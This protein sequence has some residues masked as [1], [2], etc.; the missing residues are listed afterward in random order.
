MNRSILTAWVYPLTVGLLIVGL[1]WWL[2]IGITGAQER[3]TTERLVQTLHTLE[4]ELVLLYEATTVSRTAHQSLLFTECSGSQRAAYDDA[5][6]ALDE[7]LTVSDGH[8]LLR[9]FNA[10][11]RYQAN[12]HLWRGVALE[13]HLVQLQVVL[14]LLQDHD[15]AVALL[16]QT[17]LERW[18]GLLDALYEYHRLQVALDDV[19]LALIDLRVAGRPVADLEV[20]ELAGTIAPLRA[21]LATQRELVAAAYSE[22][23]L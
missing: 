20:Q 22:L 6:R 14:S 11:G 8:R 12:A 3:A 10:C 5:L 16:W 4:Q 17:K 13:Q 18:D 21:E 23:T 1:L 2:H 7:A 19:Q 9:D 15:P